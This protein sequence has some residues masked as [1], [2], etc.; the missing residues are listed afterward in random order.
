MA[1]WRES[2]I[3]G[4]R[5]NLDGGLFVRLG[6]RQL[7]LFESPSFDPLVDDLDEPASIFPGV[8]FEDLTHKVT[9]PA[10]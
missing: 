7:A 8:N 10:S 4:P 9:H 2:S 3:D 6:I 5:P 1:G